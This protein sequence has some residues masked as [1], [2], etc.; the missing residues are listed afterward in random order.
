MALTPRTPDG[1][2]V[3]IVFAAMM[4]WQGRSVL[5]LLDIY[6]DSTVYLWAVLVFLGL[7]SLFITVAPPITDGPADGQK[8]GD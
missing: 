2:L 7:L 1:A 6:V 5:L 4:A 3:A 8:A